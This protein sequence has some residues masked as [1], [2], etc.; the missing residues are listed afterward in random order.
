MI[1]FCSSYIAVTCVFIYR[2]L[3]DTRALTPRG[4]YFF[5]PVEKSNQKTRPKGARHS[6]YSYPC[7][8][9]PWESPTHYAEI[10][11]IVIA[12]SRD[13]GGGILGLYKRAS[14]QARTN[15]GDGG[16][17]TGCRTFVP[18]AG[19]IFHFPFLIS[20]YIGNAAVSRCICALATSIHY[21]RTY[22]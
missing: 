11:V 17:C 14:L 19:V 10:V 8:A 1:S 3:R 15:R 22:I 16:W 20:N 21:K 2:S 4:G 9:P 6:L 18:P 12:W 7:V 5:S 13:R